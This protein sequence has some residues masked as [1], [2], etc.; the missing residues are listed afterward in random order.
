LEDLEDINV[1]DDDDDDD[2]KS[3]D[4]FLAA[5]ED[6]EDDEDKISYSD[7]DEDEDDDDDDMDDLEYV[8]EDED[9]EDEE[10]ED[11]VDE[12]EEEDDDEIED[13]VD[14]EDE[15]DE[16]EEEEWEYVYEDDLDREY[17]FD[18]EAGFDEDFFDDE[19]TKVPIRDYPEDPKYGE[20]N[21]LI[22]ETA[23]RRK[24]KGGYEDFDPLDYLCNNMTVEEAEA[25]D[26]LELQKET[27]KQAAPFMV[28]GP[29]DVENLDIAKE[30]FKV[31]DLYDDDPYI[32]SG[33]TDFLGTGVTD[34]DMKAMDDAWKSVNEALQREPWNKVDAKAEA[35][36][37]SKVD[38]R[39]LSEMY[40]AIEYIEGSSY[41]FPK[42]LVYDLDFNVTNLMLAAV[43]HN[44]D[45]PIF[46]MHWYAQL[47]FYS[48]YQHARDINFEFTHED[49]K[50]ADIEELERYYLGFGYDEIPKKAQG[51]TGLIS[52]EEMDEEEVKMAAFESWMKDVYNPEWDKLDFDDEDLK[53]ENN[54]FSDNFIMPNHPD[55]SYSLFSN[56]DSSF[57]LCIYNL[58]SMFPS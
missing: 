16:E 39:T 35:W 17:I 52:V 57:L 25:F 19:S 31:T 24:E 23:E 41:D 8:W 44:P 53:D 26:K 37:S 13:I 5:D 18:S 10:D 32:P 30:V 7:E 1:E 47:L 9:F 3:L 28:L 4:G 29:Q 22:E 40:Q 21:K 42:W 48:R 36:H 33:E 58:I 6:D 38:N 20:R 54:V 27:E 51:E 46:L 12:E 50:N 49:V 14:E 55:V 45:A 34:D 43:K 2:T 56:I 11:L 15:I